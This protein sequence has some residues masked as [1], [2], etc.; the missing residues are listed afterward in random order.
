MALLEGVRSIGEAVLERES[1]VETLVD[2]SLLG[3]R[4]RLVVVINLHLD[5]PGIELDL[6]GLDEKVLRSIRW[7]G[8]AQG[9]SLKD[10]LTTTSLK[11][12]ASQVVP[13]L[14]GAL[15]DGDLKRRLKLLKDTLYIDLGS[16]SEVFPDGGGGSG[17]EH[18][19]YM[20][21]LQK[22]GISDST[23]LHSL[24]REEY[25]EAVAI[26]NHEKVPFLSRE[27]LLAYARRRG[28]AK[29]ACE[30]VGDVLNVWITKE[31]QADRDQIRLYTL[32]LDGDLLAQHPDYAD[33]LAKHLVAKPFSTR[34]SHRGICH[35]CNTVGP[36][37]ADTT[38]F[39]LLKFYITDKPGFASGL[40]KSGF[41]R[42][43][44]LCQACYQALLSGERFIQNRL[45]TRLG[46]TYVYVIPT[47]HVPE[48]FPSVADLET[49]AEYLVH[50]LN[51]SA[52]IEGW[53]RFQLSMKQYQKYEGKNAAFALNLLFLTR[54]KGRSS[55]KV[56]KL[57]VE[58]PPSRLDVL[59]NMRNHVRDKAVELL[60]NRREWDIGLGVLFY[61]L[62]LRRRGQVLETRPYM[63][64]LDA[65]LTGRAISTSVLIPQ[66]LQ[67]A[68]I[69]R[70]ERYSQYVQKRLPG[71]APAMET[72]LVQSQLFLRYLTLLGQLQEDL[73]TGGGSPMSREMPP[74]DIE[75]VLDSDL[76]S[77]MDFLELNRTQRG[78]FLL[79]VLVAEIGSTQEQIESGKPIL[80]KIRYDGMDV[81]KVVRLANEVHDKLRQYERLDFTEGIYGVMKA[82]LASSK[83]DLESPHYNVF[84]ILNGYAYGTMKA[85]LHGMRKKQGAVPQS[86]GNT[87]AEDEATGEFLSTEGEGGDSYEQYG[88][89]E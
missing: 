45:T 52:T 84:W 48:A 85:I 30:L 22:L 24:G 87:V 19:R 9:T 15:P 68:S 1:P 7:V 5:P 38:S 10:R 65:L 47:F 25:D 80:N 18:D 42:N 46:G 70:F 35:L 66:F 21:D 44:A 72:F 20:L 29:A 74:E 16:R 64:L 36:V 28:S 69:Y 39:Q 40:Q 89:E 54:T 27:F 26:C 43:Y 60:G 51:A 61:L 79:G 34:H 73:K 82:Y 31:L 11:Y 59:D 57:I 37:T 81:H 77:W 4:G 12:L 56:D 49:W 63:E 14:L 32:A 17:H 3:K 88:S 33:Y 8:N 86:T 13:N 55:G 41:L 67:T 62:P 76:R 2:T 58:V 83:L 50:R 71:R 75:T 78:L 23:L 6:R 53:K